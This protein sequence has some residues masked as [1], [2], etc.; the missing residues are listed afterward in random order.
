MRALAYVFVAGIA[1]L[2]VAVS[3]L[4]CYMLGRKRAGLSPARV[5]PS[6]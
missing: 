3:A 2:F 5:A 6:Q 4:E 1:A